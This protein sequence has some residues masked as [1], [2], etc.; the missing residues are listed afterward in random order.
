MIELKF[1]REAKGYT[2]EQMAQ[3]VKIGVS[4]YNMYEKG[5]RNVPDY[6]ADRIANVLQI[7]KDEIF[8]P[9]RF[10]VSKCKGG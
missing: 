9:V 4:T 7:P 3:L 2:Q 1:A 6:I 8:L 10:T 5:N